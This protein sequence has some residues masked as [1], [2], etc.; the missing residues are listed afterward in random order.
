MSDT[1]HTGGSDW[2]GID[3]GSRRKWTD[4]SYQKWARLDTRRLTRPG[5]ANKCE[6][7]VGSGQVR[8]WLVYVHALASPSDGNA[9]FALSAVCGPPGVMGITERK[10]VKLA[11][12]MSDHACADRRTFLV[13]ASADAA[14]LDR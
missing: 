13:G 9:V 7:R 11:P 2:S 14:R 12:I 10:W 8:S 1:M 4:A 6:V 5:S 3:G